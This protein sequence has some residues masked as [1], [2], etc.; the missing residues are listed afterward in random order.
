MGRYRGCPAIPARYI[1]ID[2]SDEAR[3]QVVEYFKSSER[4]AVVMGG[5][6]DFLKMPRVATVTGLSVQGS[7]PNTLWLWLEARN[8]WDGG[9]EN[10]GD[11]LAH[12]YV[13]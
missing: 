10:G 1:Y 12:D 8:A 11:I 9:G 7:P 5:G 13:L 2:P 3:T 4:H 6:D